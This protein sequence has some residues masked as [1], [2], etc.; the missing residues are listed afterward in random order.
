MA[1]NLSSLVIA[2]VMRP[3]A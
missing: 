3:G 1:S 2:V